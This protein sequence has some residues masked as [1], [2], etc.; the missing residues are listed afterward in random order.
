MKKPLTIL[1]YIFLWL[2]GLSLS[3]AAAQA[4]YTPQPGSVERKAIMDALRAGLEAFPHSADPD[5]AYRRQDVGVPADLPVRFVVHHLKVKEGWAWAE[6]DVKD[7]CCATLYALLRREERGWA[8]QGMVNPLYVVCP[9]PDRGDP[10]VQQFIYEKFAEKFPLLPRDIFP[11]VP[12]DL[13]PI[14]KNINEGLVRN[15]LVVDGS[16]VFF[17]RY[18]KRKGDWAWLKVQPRN[19]EGTLITEELEGLVHLEDG[20]WILKAAVPCCG[21]C[22]EDPDCAAGRYPKKV[23]RLFPKAPKEIFPSP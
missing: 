22:E 7:Y 17:V 14:L 13:S 15:G 20:R 1:S 8:V 23:M 2:A 21:E 3:S 11:D 16:L 9:D 10:V 19:A 18:F 5:F 12:A 4:P 6:V